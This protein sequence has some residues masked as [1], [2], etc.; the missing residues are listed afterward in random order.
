MAGFFDNVEEKITNPLFLAGAGLLS[1]EGFGGAMQGMQMGTG[2]QNQRRRQAEDAKR[3]QAYKGLLTDP[4]FTKGMD[5]RALQLAQADPE[6]GMGLFADQFKAASPTDDM[7][8]YQ[9]AKSQGFTGSFLDFDTHRRA[10]SAVRT[11]INM[12]METSYDKEIGGLLAKEFVESQ[13]AGAGASQAEADLRVM[14]S[15]L[16]NPNVYLG[17]GGE[18]V[19]ALKKAAGSLF[20]ADVAGVPEGE[21]IQRTAAKIALGLKDNL[22]GP[23]SNA[24]REFL[25]SLPANLSASPEGAKRVVEL[26]LAQRQ[27]QTERAAVARN[28]AA[29]NNG[30]LTPQVYS[31]LASIDEKWA[32]QMEGLSKQLQG[33]AQQPRRAPTTGTPMGDDPFGLRK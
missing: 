27:W 8:E 18:Q 21:I 20:G 17:T 23:M 4:N 28:F 30:R 1:G 33:G 19:Q 13:K 12:P 16:E 5:P 25:M 29:K 7:R 14:K 31:E 11:N 15:A 3:Q 10:A 2:L 22:P 24:D 9:M 26:G 32:R 6:T